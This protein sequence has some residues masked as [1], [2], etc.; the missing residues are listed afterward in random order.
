MFH[1][2]GWVGTNRRDRKRLEPEEYRPNLAESPGIIKHWAELIGAPVSMGVTPRT[3]EAILH[4]QET[5][6]QMAEVQIPA[7]FLF[8]AVLKRP[9]SELKNHSSRS[10]EDTRLL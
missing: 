6:E 8:P 3:L 10:Q 9:N 2:W 5:S 4:R 1:C 7:N